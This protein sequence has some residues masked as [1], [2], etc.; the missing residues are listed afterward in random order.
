MGAWSRQP[1][2]H[3]ERLGTFG[4]GLQACFLEG[5]CLQAGPLESSTRPVFTGECSCGCCMPATCSC[6]V[7]HQL[8]SAP[9]LSFT[10]RR[11]LMRG[12]APRFVPATPLGVVALLS[13]QGLDISGSTCVVLGDSNIVGTPLAGLL[14]DLGA[15]VVT[16]CHRMSYNEWFEGDWEQQQRARARACLPRLP[17]PQPH[18]HTPLAAAAATAV[19]GAHGRGGGALPVAQPTAESPGSQVGT[20]W[21]M[22]TGPQLPAAWRDQRLQGPVKGT[23]LDVLSWQ[24]KRRVRACAPQ[25]LV[26]HAALTHRGCIACAL[27]PAGAALGGHHCYS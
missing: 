15:A 1:H 4:G 7:P 13:R 26:V 17:G 2:A 10:R 27:T 11:T 6:P 24:W 22:C 3:R 23:E 16:I 25:R 14:R 8:R 19:A 21:P 5:A 18:V 9:L 20:M 12:L